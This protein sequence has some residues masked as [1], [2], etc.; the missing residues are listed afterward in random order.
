MSEPI[1]MF[2]NFTYSYPTKQNVLVDI[3][4]KI[5]PGETVGIIGPN[6][7]GKST[8]C[9]SLNGLV[10][11]FY[12]GSIKGRV[13]VT[14]LDTL[15]STIDELSL[16]VGLVFQEP[17][18]QLSGLALTVEDEVGFGLS[19]LGMDP[20]LIRERIKEALRIVGLEGFE[21]RSPFE[22]S[23]GEQQR[24]AIATVLAMKPEI[25]V[26]DEPVAL[27]D[28][29]GKYQVLSTVRKLAE[30][31]KLTVVIAEHEIEELATMV[32]KIV[33]LY[34]GR[35]I[36]VDN[37]RNVLSELEKLKAIG[38]DP[39]SITELFYMF[40]KELGIKFDGLPI[41]L[42]EG[43]RVLQEMMFYE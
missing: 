43:L 15:K 16:K 4:L 33:V 25:I 26:L 11:H 10:P 13:Y 6:G 42:S 32:D 1:I 37:S 23:G 12:G 24:L 34:D 29:I 38:V 8:L 31:E 3:N 22:L 35:L 21:K 7:S 5:Y 18:T 9:K 30:E 20:K 40:Q 28:P 19:M 17:E 2:D 36:S 39:P 27:L 41:T 14:G